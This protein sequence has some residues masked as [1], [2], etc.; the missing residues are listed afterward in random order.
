MCIYVRISI[1]LKN[2]IDVQILQVRLVIFK[3]MKYKSVFYWNTREYKEN[4]QI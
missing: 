4:Y 2:H 3:E 1:K